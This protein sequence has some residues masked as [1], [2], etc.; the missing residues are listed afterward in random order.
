MFIIFLLLCIENALMF[1]TLEGVT[2]A[3]ILIIHTCGL[4]STILFKLSITKR[5]YSTVNAVTFN[6]SLIQPT[7]TMYPWSP[8]EYVGNADKLLNCFSILD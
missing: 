3:S 8:T 4:Q 5:L 1:P 6:R 2:S 7:D